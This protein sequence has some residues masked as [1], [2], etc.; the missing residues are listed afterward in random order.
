MV[1]EELLSARAL[2]LTRLNTFATLL[3]TMSVNRKTDGVR[4]VRLPRH[5]IC[6]RSHIRAKDMYE[7]ILFNWLSK[8][9]IIPLTLSPF[10]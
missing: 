6:Q 4:R 3:R 5:F 9:G 1:W 8:R 2:P 7:Q 10:A